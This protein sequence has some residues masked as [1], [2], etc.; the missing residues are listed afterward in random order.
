MP[1]ANKCIAL[2]GAT[3]FIGRSVLKVLIAKN[4]RVQALSRSDQI[5]SELAPDRLRFITGNLGDRRALDALAA[6]ADTFIHIAGLTK[7]RTLKQLLEVNAQ[8]ALNA[9]QAARAAGVRRF[10]LV[11]SLAARAPHLSSYAQS[12]RT[13][14]DAVENYFSDNG[15]EFVIVRPPAIIGPGDDATAPM[16]DI[17][18]RGLLPAPAGKA[19]KNGRMSFVYVDDIARFLVEQIE[20]EILQTILS[21]HGATPQSSWQDL[22]NSAAEVLS[23]PVRVIPI[24][25]TIL[26]IAA[27]ISQT[28]S[29]LFFKS[30]H[31]N[32]GKVREL[33]HSDWTG[34]R[35]IEN[36]YTLVQPLRLSFEMDDEV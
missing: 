20:A 33:L 34:E 15:P 11:S 29:A 3:G 13:G 10:I 23:K 36:S 9:A 30:G 32:T 27:F 35:K 12:K 22:A 7:A 28:A 26:F 18:K 16:L 17:L 21:P 6:G 8:G 2:T 1:G 19:K 14:E 25:P 4:Y 31:F 24:P 5:K